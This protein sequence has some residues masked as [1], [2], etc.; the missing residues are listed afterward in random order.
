MYSKLQDGSFMICGFVAR[1]AE[2][3][4][5]QN[6]KVMTVWSV[7]VGKKGQGDQEQTIW[8]NCKA[9]GREPPQAGASQCSRAAKAGDVAA[10]IRKG[11]TV[12]CIGRL[13]T[14][15][16]NGKTYKN[17]VCEYVSIMGSGARTGNLPPNAADASSPY[18]GLEEFETILADDEVPF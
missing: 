2:Q 12:L 15:D 8:T 7:A 5:T 16:Y 4:T 6:G 18:G 3:K 11:D 1:D 17:L 14:N 13:E 9:W 10:T